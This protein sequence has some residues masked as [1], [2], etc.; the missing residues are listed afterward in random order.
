MTL[1]HIFAIAVAVVA[2]AS[3][4]N[5]YEVDNLNGLTVSSSYVSLPLAGGANNVNITSNDAWELDTTGTVVKGKKWLEFSSLSGNA[6]EST[7]TIKAEA[8]ENGRSAEVKLKSGNLVQRINI[9][10]G[11]PVAT[12]ATCAEV[13]AGPDAKTY[14]VTGTVTKISNT[15]YG[16]FY[17]AD[18][19]GEVYIYGTLDKNGKEKNFASLGIE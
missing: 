3:C 18:N 15:S 4:S 8:T 19:T 6:G 12:P 11:L 7:L 14:M 16:N 9:I 17:L 1:K 2:F 10:Q 5:D 13:L